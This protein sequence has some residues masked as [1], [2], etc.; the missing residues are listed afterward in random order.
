M[1]FIMYRLGNNDKG[2][3]CTGSSRRPAQRLLKCLLFTKFCAS[4][5]WRVIT[6]HPQMWT[7]QSKP[8]PALMPT[9]NTETAIKT[10]GV[11]KVT[12]STFWPTTA[13]NRDRILL[14]P[15]R[16]GPKRNLYQHWSQ[17]CPATWRWWFWP[18]E[19]TCS[20]WRFGAES[21]Y[22]G[23]GDRWLSH[24]DHLI[25]DQPGTAGN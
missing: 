13:M 12:S 19:N 14:S 17:P 6:L 2:K 25:M 5:A 24:R 4:S 18:I 3:V 22:K 23:A 15:T 7:G 20:V 21:L 10:K 16:E 9:R 1:T 11:N 8:T